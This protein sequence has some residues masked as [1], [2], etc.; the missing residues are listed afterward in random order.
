MLSFLVR[1]LYLPFFL[2]VGNG[3]AIF[4]VQRG[5]SEGWLIALLVTFIA[6]AFTGERLAPYDSAFNHSQGDRSRDFTHALVNESLSVMGVL[7]IPLIAHL[8][9]LPAYWPTAWPLWQQLLMAILIADVGITLVHYA[10]HR[11]DLLWRLHSVHHSVKRMYGFNGLMKHPLHQTLETLAGSVPLLLLGVPQQ[12]LMLLV[13]AVVLQLLLQHSNVA[14]FTGPLKRVLA[15]NVVHRFHHLNTAAEGDVNFG[16]FT[17]FTDYLLGTVYFDK[18]RTFRS[19]DLGI[20]DQPNY[21]A[22]YFSQMVEPFKKG[23]RQEVSQG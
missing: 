16:L 1:L 15:V 17:T 9:V 22:D 14:Y 5:Y 8:I 21:P 12:V 7:S 20:S 19:A 18:D 23:E 4:V 2:L 6:L 10:S 3:L 13:V 11:I